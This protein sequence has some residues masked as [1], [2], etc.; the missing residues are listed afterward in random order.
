MKA[1]PLKHLYHIYG[2]D[3]GLDWQ[4]IASRLQSADLIDM[5]PEALPE[6]ENFTHYRP[7]P[8]LKALHRAGKLPDCL[9]PSKSLREPL[10]TLEESDWAADYR[11]RYEEV[12]LPGTEAG[13]APYPESVEIVALEVWAPALDSW[14]SVRLDKLATSELKEFEERCL[15][16]ARQNG[17]WSE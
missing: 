4:D 5:L 8:A 1:R 12:H 7:K 10:E 16:N 3:S 13:S 9:R 11:V 2:Q 6:G 14:V 15:S 17:G